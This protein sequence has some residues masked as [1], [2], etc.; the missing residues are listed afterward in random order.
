[1]SE[2]IGPETISRRDA[3]S[4]LGLAAT[5]SLVIASSVLAPSDAEAYTYGMARRQNR[6]FARRT[7]RYTRRAIRRY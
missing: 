6:R 4:F 7:G 2:K 1:M 5:S 3:L